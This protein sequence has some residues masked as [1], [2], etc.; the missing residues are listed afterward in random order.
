MCIFRILGKQNFS[1]TPYLWFF[2]KGKT[3][4]KPQ[5]L[6]QFFLSALYCLTYHFKAL[7][8]LISDHFS[9]IKN[10][11]PIKSYKLPNFEKSDKNS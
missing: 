7:R 5:N 8:K 11:V 9:E 6:S 4:K 3:L 1:R 10:K 2:K